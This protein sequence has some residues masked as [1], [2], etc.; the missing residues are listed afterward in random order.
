M[1][2]IIMYKAFFLKREKGFLLALHLYKLEKKIEEI[3]FSFTNDFIPG[4]P[5]I[6]I[7]KA[8]YLFI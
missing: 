2:L 3:P 4:N 7:L 8:P 1:S 6:H 5:Y